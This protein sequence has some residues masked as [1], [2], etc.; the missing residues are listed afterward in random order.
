MAP[1]YNRNHAA[2]PPQTCPTF[3]ARAVI[4]TTMPVAAQSFQSSDAG[5]LSSRLKVVHHNCGYRFLMMGKT[6]SHFRILEAQ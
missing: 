3:I 5:S 1:I 6:I 4:T 2:G